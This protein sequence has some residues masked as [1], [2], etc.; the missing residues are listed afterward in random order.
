MSLGRLGINHIRN[1]NSASL[2]LVPDVNLFLGANGSG[3]TSLLESI[4]FLGTGRTFRSVSV[5]PLISRGQPSC[6]VYGAVFDGGGNR[7]T[8]G[9]TRERSGGREIKVN[10]APVKRASQLARYLPTLV[11]GPDT[12]ELVTGPPAYRR[13]FLNW[14]VFHVEPSFQDT[15]EQANRCLRQRNELL[16]RPGMTSRELQ[17]WD[18]QLAELGTQIDLLRRHWV[19]AFQVAFSQV[20]E[21]LS[22]V[23]DV[24]CTYQRGWDDAEPLIQVLKRQQAADLGRGYTQA[25]FHRADLQLR[26]GKSAAN[27]VCSRGELKVLAWAMVL[28]Q[29]R[30]FTEH[31]GTDLVYLVDD[32]A[33]ELDQVHRS[34]VC[35]L[36]TEMPGQVLVTGIDEFQ[37]K[38]LWPVQPKVFH[39]EHGSFSAEETVDERR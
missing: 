15:W 5:D 26:V 8:L 16:R 24:S 33:S 22:R 27:A 37:L 28:S 7:R 23:P 30:V 35:E 2:E 39:V 13:R 25:G 9:V 20:C 10:G 34:K 19:Q 11:L 31:V 14:G 1:I 12:V 6:T 4:Y 17:T 21:K 3:K 32:L 29:G 36:L 18:V 38:G